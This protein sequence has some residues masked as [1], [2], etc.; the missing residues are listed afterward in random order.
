MRKGDLM[1]MTGKL[2]TEVRPAR[3]ASLGSRVKGAFARTPGL[4]ARTRWIVAAAL[5]VV[6]GAG[7]AYYKLAYAPAQAS[8]AT[9]AM[10]TSTVREG[11]LVISATGSGTLVSQDEVDL[12]FQTSGTVTEVNV[13]VGDQVQKGALLAS[14]DDA[15]LR[16]AYTEARR[17]YDELTSASAIVDAEAAVATA[18]ANLDEAKQHLEYVISP[19]V[20]YWEN[21]VQAR[22]TALEAAQAAAAASPSDK[23]AQAAVETAQASI[24]SATAS[25]ASAQ[26][27]YENNYVKNNFVF[28]ITDQ[29]THRKVRYDGAPSEADILQARADVAA[30][31]STLQ[32]AQW[33]YAALTGAEVPE[34]ATG[35]SLTA[36]EQARLKLQ[37]AQEA[38]DNASLKATIPG[39][40]M[41]VDITAGETAKSGTTAITISDLS[42]PYLE[43]F[44]DESDWSNVKVGEEA[45]ITFDIL[46][47]AAFT[48]VVTQVDPGL[49]SQN[50]QSVVRAYV[51][52]SD[53]DAARPDLPLGTA[54][55]VEVIAARA[56][57]A[58]LVSIDALH[59]TDDGTYTVFVL[60]NGTPKLRV[61]EIGLQ[62]LVNAQVTSGLEVGDVV[63]TGITATK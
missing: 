35:S 61:V 42:Q 20:Y 25:L 44:L 38:L 7:L 19:A 58:V 51:Q 29:L 60:E 11:S 12:A 13:K 53:D 2:S 9:P 26:Y 43:V 33:L 46:P 40:V 48:G 57:N 5:V 6:A 27:D 14:I 52:L 36:L 59:K 56:E 41:A 63:T 28:Y 30:A 21:Q 50:G 10:Q 55:S 32:Q 39:T 49:Y 47:D 16:V 31:K 18:Q 8:A 34:D 3:G 54:A 24:K 22:Q 17:A 15:D 62:D 4:S 37:D 45:D 23:D 1:N